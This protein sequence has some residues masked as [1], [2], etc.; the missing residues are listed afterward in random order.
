MINVNLEIIGA[1]LDAP[2]Q[3]RW[4]IHLPAGVFL[5]E[6]EET[7]ALLRSGGFGAEWLSTP[8]YCE[9]VVTR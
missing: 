8:W 4:E 9:V 1:I 6:V 2:E 5:S 3:L 7:C